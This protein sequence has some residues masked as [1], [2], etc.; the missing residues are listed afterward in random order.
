MTIQVQLDISRLDA[1]T[2]Q[3]WRD[4]H[5][6]EAVRREGELLLIRIA[7]LAELPDLYGQPLIARALNEQNPILSVTPR[8]NR[9]ERDR[10]AGVFFLALAALR[11]A[12]N[13]YTHDVKTPVDPAEATMWLSTLQ[14]LNQQLDRAAQI[15]SPESP[16]NGGGGPPADA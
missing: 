13:L 4:G 2:E 15:A 16:D 1:Q 7:E 3:L 5:L 8:S 9:I 10:H 14:Y 6:G 12:R 11:G